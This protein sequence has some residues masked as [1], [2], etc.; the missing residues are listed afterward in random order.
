MVVQTHLQRHVYLESLMPALLLLLI[1][2]FL[3]SSAAA[4]KLSSI[5]EELNL[6]ALE[7]TFDAPKV[8]ALLAN[9]G[10]HLTSHDRRSAAVLVSAGILRA[11]DLNDESSITTAFERYK[12]ASVGK[13]DHLMGPLGD[14]VTLSRLNKIGDHDELLRE[15]GFIN[16][17]QQLLSEGVITGYD[18]RKVNISAGFDPQRTLTYSHSSVVHLKQLNALL[19]SENINGLLYAAPKVSA[20]LF[21]DEWGVPGDNVETLVDGTRVVHGRE[22]VVFFEFATAAEKL[23]FHRI[24]TRYAKKDDENEQGL[25]A[26]AWWQPFYYSETMI[27][28]F[29]HINLILLRSDTTEATL[30]VLP[31]KVASVTEALADQPFNTT[32][33]DV[34]V[35]KPFYRFLQGDYK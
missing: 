23:D 13:S 11:S 10:N 24:V 33:E 16:S 35:N 3:G 8:D 34:W 2:L 30:T 9:S 26:D 31:E 7:S 15:G 22:W 4:A 17:L 19:K 12:L 5:V 21:R 18:L 6:Q 27:E 28:A 20:F 14:S 1:S 29:E 25:I 32:I